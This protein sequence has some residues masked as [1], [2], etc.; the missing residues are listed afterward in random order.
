M[1]ISPQTA[2]NPYPKW[3]FFELGVSEIASLWLLSSTKR[4][5][6]WSLLWD[7]CFFSL[8]ILFRFHSSFFR[9]DILNESL[10]LI[11]GHRCISLWLEEQEVDAEDLQRADCLVVITVLGQAQSTHCAIMVHTHTQSLLL[12]S[13]LFTVTQPR[14]AISRRSSLTVRVSHID[15]KSKPTNGCSTPPTPS[16]RCRR[17]RSATTANHHL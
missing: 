6:C 16:I 4:V 2:T 14:T 8:F 11:D 1:S 12:W 7:C 13:S 15:R 17:R 5:C 9:Y 10:I 3:D